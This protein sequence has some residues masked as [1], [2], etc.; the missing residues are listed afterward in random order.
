METTMDAIVYTGPG[1]LERR[2][3]PRPVP[4]PGQVLVEV[5]HAGICG[6]DLLV[7]DGGLARVRPPVVLGHEFSGTVVDPNGA[8]GV[9]EGDRVAVEPLL[10]CGDCPGCREGEQTQCRR[11]RLVGIDVDGAAARWVRVPADRLHRLPDHVTLRQGALVEPAAV[12]VHMV[13]RA[14]VRTGSSVLVVGGG[15]IGALAGLVARAHGA[16]R[17]VV[18]EPHAGRR[19]LLA[20]LGLKTV[21]PT[22]PDIGPLADLAGGD[23]FDVVVEVTGV[24][25]G[26][27]AAVQ[28]A[29]PGGTVLLG[30]LPHTPVPVPVARAVLGELTLRGA[31]VYRTDDVRRAIELIAAGVLPVDRLVTHEVPLADAVDGAYGALRRGRDAMKI[32]I[33][34]DRSAA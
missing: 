8:P 33:T 5:A 16:D 21:D 26:L 25:A 17:L 14:G 20:D 32:L 12:A 4:E 31:R 27:D 9:A 24:E 15:P 23:G 29:R 7:A 6:S 10:T 2:R 13:R 19:A 11:L 28:A 22:R 34:P 1:T 18:S 3:V 30:G